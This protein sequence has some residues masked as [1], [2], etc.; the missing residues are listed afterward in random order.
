MPAT[1]TPTATADR[2]LGRRAAALY[3]NLRTSSATPPTDPKRAAD[4]ALGK[5][6]AALY[7]RMKATAGVL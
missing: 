4:R 5:Q 2:E 1:L 6:A 3:R 7:N